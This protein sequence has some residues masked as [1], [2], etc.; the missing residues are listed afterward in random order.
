MKRINL[1]KS[2]S[3]SVIITAALVLIAT[4]TLETI[5]HHNHLRCPTALLAVLR[6]LC[7]WCG[8]R[9]DIRP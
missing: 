3:L 9:M 6:S 7:C 2:T 8:N 4:P 1:F 5:V